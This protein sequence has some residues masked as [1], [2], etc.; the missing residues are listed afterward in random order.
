M[1]RVFQQKKGIRP[2]ILKWKLL[3]CMA[4][5]SVALPL[6]CANDAKFDENWVAIWST[7]NMETANP[8]MAGLM[9]GPRDFREFSN[10]TIREIVHTT[11]AGSAARIRFANTFGPGPLTFDAIYIGKQNQ[12]A[13]V[14]AGSNY[15]VTFGGAKSIVIPEGADALSDVIPLATAAQQNVVISLYISK[16]TGPATFHASAFQTNYVSAEGNHAAE[17]GGEAFSKAISSWFFLASLEV[18]APKQTA[19][20]IVALG[21]SITDGASSR[22]DANERWTDV[23]A[24]RLNGNSSQPYFA[25]LNAG[26]G[27]NR[28][29]SSSP[30]FGENA[31][32]RL[33]R[34]VFAPAGVRSVILFE[35]TN[36][37]GQPDTH[38][39]PKYVPCLAKTHITADD[40][41]AGYKQIIAQ[42]HARHLK[43]FGATILP[44]KGFN[45]YTE[46]GEAKR[47]AVNRW[48]KES[49]SFDGVID[50]SAALTDPEDP[51]KLAA[52]YDSGDHLHPGTEGHAA[53]ALA[54]D[55]SMLTK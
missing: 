12:G 7:S 36:D 43:I 44:F 6:A 21:D 17:E 22:P 31:L 26:I 40:L 45:G 34:D 30:C 32:A 51:A 4:A 29:L 41:I 5:L 13:S 20:A 54:I 46:K 18:L 33:D 27:G 55:L 25:V 1:L 19:G 23:L 49:H 37:I 42:V 50:F 10:Q 8:V 2:Q 35:G 3:L 15:A 11:V 24:R 9:T 28:V 48:I 39:D 53:M 16:P 38:A 52:K 14:V 47:L